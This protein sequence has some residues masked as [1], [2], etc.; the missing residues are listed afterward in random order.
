MQLKRRAIRTTLLVAT[1]LGLGGCGYH[2]QSVY[3][4]DVHSVAVP[5]FTTKDF[6][7]GI[8]FKLTQ[9]IIVQIEARTPY[10][11]ESRERADTIL[12]GEVGLGRYGDVEQ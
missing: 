3:R 11:V 6:R 12:E 1:L 4:Q 8:E 9:A 2:W 10:K 5:I 7:R